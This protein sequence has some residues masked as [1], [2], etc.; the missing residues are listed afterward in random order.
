M[1][2]TLTSLPKRA[3]GLGAGGWRVA[4]LS[5]RRPDLRRPGRVTLD[6]I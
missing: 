3:S 1:A 2:E 6:L 4:D 5:E